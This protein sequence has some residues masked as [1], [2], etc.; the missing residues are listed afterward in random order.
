MLLTIDGFIGEGGGQILRTAIAL[1][2]VMQKGIRIVNVRKSRPRP[3]LGIQHMKSIEIARDMTDAAVEGLYPGS[4]EVTFIP[5]PIKSGEYVVNMGTAGS[6]TLALQSILPIAAYAPGQVT[7]DIT[8]GTDVKWSPPYDYFENVTVPA[9]ARFGFQVECRLAS[10]GY[11]PLG[12]GRAIVRTS[13]ARLLGIDLTGPVGDCV[14]GISASS[15][16]PSHV[17]ERQAKAAK[18]YLRS[19]GYDVGDIRLD[20]RSDTSTGSSITLFKG[21]VGGSALGERGKPAEKV[22]QEASSHIVE[23]LK[24]GAA[25]DAHLADQLIIY[26]A[27]ADGPSS[28]TTSRTTGHTSSGILVAGQMLGRDFEVLEKKVTVIRSLGTRAGSGPTGTQGLHR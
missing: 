26:M 6:I 23:E 11:F 28:I 12:N 24:A 10:R 2:A 13:P 22:G 25:V 16:L 20:V 17:V 1:S 19:H 8:G 27:L 5:G 15:R 4:T 7:L 18:D 14:R 21:Y 9:L 3:G